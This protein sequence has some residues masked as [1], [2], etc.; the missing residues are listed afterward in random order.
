MRRVGPH[1]KIFFHKKTNV[2]RYPLKIHGIIAKFAGVFNLDNFILVVERVHANFHREFAAG[3]REEEAVR[4]D[5][6]QLDLRPG[7][8]RGDIFLEPA[9]IQQ[10]TWNEINQT[11]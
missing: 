8:H 3:F 7:S 9:N 6:L 2:Q 10:Y 4:R 1:N 5:F 11:Q